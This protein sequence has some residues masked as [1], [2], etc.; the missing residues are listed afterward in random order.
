MI[1]RVG[2]TVAAIGDLHY[3]RNATPGSLQPLLSQVNESADV[4]VICGDLTDHGNPDEYANLRAVLAA[5]LRKDQD[6]LRASL[7]LVPA[8]SMATTLAVVSVIWPGDLDTAK[9]QPGGWRSS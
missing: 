2:G 8:E 6:A 4:L 5:A 9:Q 7:Q 3:G 1:T